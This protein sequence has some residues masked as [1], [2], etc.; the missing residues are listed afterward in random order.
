MNFVLKGAVV[1]A[2]VAI[3]APVHA[4]DPVGYWQGTLD[5][6]AGTLP[7]GVNI[8]GGGD[9]SLSGS[10]DSPSQQAF[11]IPVSNV[12]AA[13]DRLTFTVP[14]VGGSYEGE[15]QAEEKRWVGSWSQG[16]ATFALSL[17]AGERP[18][19][20]AA[21]SPRTLP[22]DW[23][24]PNEEEVAAV[25]Q[26]R[27]ANR[28]GTGMV[29]G[30]VDGDDVQTI[31]RGPSGAASFDA[32]TLFEIGSMTKVFTGLLLAD[33]AADGVVSLDDPVSKHLPAGATMPTRGGK[34][35]TLR[36]L[37]QQDSGLPRLPDNMVPGD[38]SNP[39]AD[40]SEQQLLDFLAGYELPRD[41]GSEYEYSNLGVGLLGYALARAAGSD[42]ETLLRERILTPL[43]M[44]DTAIALSADQQARFAGGRDAFNRPTSAWDLPVLAGAG[45]LRSTANDML[46]FMRAALDPQ[47][48][49]S[50]E[51]QLALADPREGPGF[52][53]GLGWMI[54][55]APSGTIVMHG[56]GTGGF[57]THMALQPA[58][59][60]A[61]VVLTN[62][63]V[64]PGAQDIAFHLLAGGPVAEA[65][66]VPQ[67]AQ[68]VQRDEIANLTEAQ[69]DRVLGKWRLTPE[70]AIDITRDGEQLYAAVTGQ[71]ALPIFARSPLAFFWRAANAEIVFTEQ[72]G[73]IT[74]GMFTQDGN[75]IP[76]TRAE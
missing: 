39:Y 27:L 49:I 61:V 45:A 10:I 64:D 23:D 8:E 65:G 67:A 7:I 70:L 17:T 46:K 42:Y 41:I 59:N 32:D 68:Q 60:R 54:L 6:G 34:Q 1:A 19:R 69:Q 15:W 29:V 9:G 36:N 63:A 2:A 4:Q 28:P 58:N 73:R 35:I 74:G 76:V 72:D 71:A 44:D 26:E 43:G 33:M 38:A 62:S 56:G 52:G 16:G 55:P 25:I 21:A 11:G 22:A 3:A 37:S 75:S 20:P 24:I 51:M 13:G 53:A 14:A 48:P 18:P 31:A 40:Y 12:E 50:R 47:S 66:A 57:R 5:T 30:L